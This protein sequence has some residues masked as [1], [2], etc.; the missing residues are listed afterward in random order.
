MLVKLKSLS[1]LNECPY[2]ISSQFRIIPPN[3]LK[4]T[5]ATTTVARC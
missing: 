3:A 2:S 4:V 5:A 1:S